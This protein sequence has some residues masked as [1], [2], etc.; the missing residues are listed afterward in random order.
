MPIQPHIKEQ[1]DETI[2]RIE[3]DEFTD[4]IFLEIRNT[5]KKEVSFASI[6]L[7][8][9]V[10][11]F[12]GLTLPE[13]WLAGI[14]AAFDGILLLHYYQTETGPA[15]KGLVGVDAVT[16][17]TLWSN[18]NFALDHLSVNGPVVYDTRLQPRKLFL[19][20]V[21][22]GA[23]TRVYE[24]SV[25]QELTNCIVLPLLITPDEMPV[26]LLQVH[27]VGNMVH[28]V[29]H[30][31]FRIV[32]LHALKGEGLT[33]SLFIFDDAEAGGYREDYEDLLNAEIQK[34]QPEA[35]IMHKNRLI[36]LK[37]KSELKVINL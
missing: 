12:K 8:S 32:S 22:T 5:E 31:N 24:P 1:F 13:R 28:Y 25:Y 17:E 6:D 26:K 10:V 29:E 23:T 15:H 18:Y 33:Q 2:W 11:N 35:F 16:G 20:D 21:K 37:N 30:N 9:G 36:Y 7:N 4:T 27:P 3:I 19:A 34:I 14:E